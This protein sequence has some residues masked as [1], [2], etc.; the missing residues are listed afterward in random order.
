MSKKLEGKVAVGTGASAGI[1]LDVYDRYVAELM[2]QQRRTD[3]IRFAS[4]FQW[5]IV[6]RDPEATFS[7]AADHIHYQANNYTAWLSRAG[8]GVHACNVGRR[9]GDSHA[10]I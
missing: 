6:S 5:L 7:E 8:H 3:K 4:S 1:G 9:H 10:T 2:K